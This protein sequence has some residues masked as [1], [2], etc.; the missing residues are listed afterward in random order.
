MSKNGILLNNAMSNFAIPNETEDLETTSN[1]IAQGRRP[2][3]S[4]LVVLTMD[5]QDI[6]GQRIITGGATP[7]SVGQ[8]KIKAKVHFF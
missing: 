6:C 8:V 3:T 7:S 5:T 4:N 2:L 1:Q